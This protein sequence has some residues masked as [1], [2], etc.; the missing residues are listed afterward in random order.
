MKST[1]NKLLLT[2]FILL[3]ISIHLSLRYLPVFVSINGDSDITIEVNSDYIDQGATNT[4]TK[5]PISSTGSVDT[6]KL[7]DY[8]LEYK[9]FIQTLSRT[10]HVIDTT[11]PSIELVGKDIFLNVNENY[12]EPG[13]SIIDNYD[14]DLLNNLVIENDI[15]NQVPGKY[16]VSYKVVDNSNNISD[17]ITRNVYVIEDDFN[18]L[19]NIDDSYNL[20][21][22]I[23]KTITDYLNIYYRSLKYLKTQDFSLLFSDDY[24]DKAYLV[25]SALDALVTYRNNSIND[26]KMDECSYSIKTLEL[27][28]PSYNIIKVT[29]LEDSDLKFHF[30]NGISSKQSKVWNYFYLI[31]EDDEYKLT[32]VL[33]EEGI[34]L[35]FDGEYENGGITQIDQIKNNYLDL[36]NTS[37]M[38]YENQRKQV[39]DGAQYT[40]KQA[41]HPYDRNS[42]K[43]YA[44]KYGD[45]RH[46]NYDSY[47]SNCNN[48]VS[49]VI[50]AGGVPMDSV[51]SYQW[52]YFNTVHD[53]VSQGYGY[54][55]S[56]TYIPS[57]VE[58]LNNGDIVNDQDVNLYFAKSGDVLAVDMI[59]QSISRSPHVIIISDQVLD[60]DGNI[61]DLLVCG[62]TNDQVNYPLSAM[63]YAYKKL[64]KI[65]GYN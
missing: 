29:F 10:V 35:Y 46:P 6:S 28:Y 27:S 51:G 62:N 30:L 24:K 21:K 55:Y 47:E 40:A 17:T 38:M 22:K 14:A 53:E 56:W 39:N 44:I 26:L 8:K 54:S 37:N 63:T 60:K 2:L 64:I 25:N 13:V 36:M 49:Q 52:K 48:F 23:W 58:Y 7:G 12:E 61:I 3:V 59:D 20:D 19:T 42:A 50:N 33:R 45:S 34:F 43:A 65:E 18:Y 5:K 16:S 31:N 1:R 32:E 9:A 4:I 11:A 41:T 15:N 57:F